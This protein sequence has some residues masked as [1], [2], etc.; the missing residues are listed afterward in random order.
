MVPLQNALESLRRDV[1]SAKV[2]ITE[3]EATIRAYD[4]EIAEAELDW[5]TVPKLTPF[6]SDGEPVLCTTY[7]LMIFD[8]VLDFDDLIPAYCFQRTNR[9][10]RL[11]ARKHFAQRP[12]YFQR[13]PKLD[14]AVHC[15]LVHSATDVSKLH[16]VFNFGEGKGSF[17]LTNTCNFHQCRELR[18]CIVPVK[19]YT[20]S[21]VLLMQYAKRDDK[22]I[23]PLTDTLNI[24][25][26]ST[27]GTSTCAEFDIE[28]GKLEY[29]DSY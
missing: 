21:C 18:F 28:T 24:Y 17:S 5:D 8:H 27:M 3:Y 7:L 22:S 20:D 10:F 4:S 2:E 15:D 25:Q 12:I 29:V 14:T 9:D 1:K 26:D 23:V 16:I 6:R 19:Q 13:I 11:V